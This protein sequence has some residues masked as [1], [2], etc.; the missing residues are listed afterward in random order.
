MC[1]IGVMQTRPLIEVGFNTGL[2]GNRPYTCALELR[3]TNPKVGPKVGDFAQPRE[4]V[5]RQGSREFCKILY[6]A[7]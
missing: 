1:C 6:M 5:A 7:H 3:V 4:A 2:W